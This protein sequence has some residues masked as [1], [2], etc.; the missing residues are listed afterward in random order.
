MKIRLWLVVILVAPGGVLAQP[1]AFGLDDYSGE[2][3]YQRF[4]SAC[5][6]ESAHG[7]GPVAQ[8]LTVPVPDL[9]Q[10][11]RRYGNTFPADALREIIDGRNLVI[12]H[13]SRTMPVWG[14]EFWWEDGADA[15]A[16]ATARATINRLLE[17]LRSIQEP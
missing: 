12:A 7:D 1:G 13:G 6:G 4:C 14:Y 9:T 2:E 11:E 16:E 8:S 15:E 3:L 10:L 5:H 17:Y